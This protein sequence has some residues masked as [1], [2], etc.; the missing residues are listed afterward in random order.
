MNPLVPCNHRE[1]PIIDYG[2]H[3]DGGLGIWVSCSRCG[4]SFLHIPEQENIK[5][6]LHPLIKEHE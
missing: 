2:Y 3:P 1:R 6:N 5:I 4:Y